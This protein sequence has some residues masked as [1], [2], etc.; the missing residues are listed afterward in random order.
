MSWQ[1]PRETAEINAFLPQNICELLLKHKPGCR[2]FHASSSDIFGDGFSERQNE[3]THC[4]PKSPYGVA[5]LY[6]HHIVGAYRKQ[7]GLHACS[8]ILFNHES[9]YRPLG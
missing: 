2:L 6:G 5:K 3:H 7:Y 1:V 9:P 8:G 4:M